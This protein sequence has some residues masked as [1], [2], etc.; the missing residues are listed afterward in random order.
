M[1]GRMTLCNMAIEA[2]ARVGLVGVDDKTIDYL[3][4]RPQAPQGAQ[5]NAAVA[6]W[7]T[8]VSD[9][10]AVFDQELTIDASALQPMV[11]WG[12]SPEMVVPLNGHVPDPAHERDAVRRASME[13]ALTYMDLEPGTPMRD[14]RID[15][16]FIGSCTNA[17]IEDLRAAASVV[18]GRHVASHI[19]H[20][21]AH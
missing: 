16:V 3:R 21:Q 5:W 7:R 12:T 10:G 14:I 9:E 4:G 1:E 17:R 2:G 6:S 19:V 11:T 8:L 20:A 18:Q 13:A 15:K